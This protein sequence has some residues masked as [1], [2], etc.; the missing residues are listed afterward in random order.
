MNSKTILFSAAAAGFLFCGC[1]NQGQLPVAQMVPMPVNNGGNREV[2]IVP[3]AIP[4]TPR[5]VNNGTTGGYAPSNVQAQLKIDVK[6]STKEVKVIRDNTDPFVI[7]KPYT[8]KNADPYAVRSYLEAAVGARSISANPAQVMAVKMADGTGIV[9]VSAEEY[10]FK[11][12]KAGKGI[13]SIIKS[14]DRKGLSYAPEAG[15][16]V[17]FPRISRAA[18]LRDM[19]LKVGSHELDPQFAVAPSC[20]VVDGE[21][22]ALLVKAP[23]WSWREMQKLL[24]K[25]DRAIPEVKISYRVLEIY[26]ENDDRIGVDFQSWKNNE[27][28]DFFS[29]GMTSRRNWGTFFTSG[30]HENGWNRTSYWNFNPKWNTRYLDFMTSIGKAKCLARGVLVAQNRRSTQLQVGSGF[31][32]DRTYYTAGA[33]TIAE[34]TTEFAYLD[35][36]PDAIQ[37]EGVNKIMPYQ[38]LVRFYG[39]VSRD[40]P[41]SLPEAL[42]SAMPEKFL[43][44]ITYTQRVMGIQK[45]TSIYGDVLSQVTDAQKT[46]LT[47]QVAQAAAARAAAQIAAG[48]AA[49][50]AAA[51]GDYN[52]TFQAV[53]DAALPQ[54]LATA[55]PQVTAGMA[56][57]GTSALSQYFGGFINSSGNW[58]IPG[59]YNDYTDRDHANTHPGI[60]HG[61]LQYPMVTDGF[62]FDLKVRPEVTGKAAKLRFELDSVSLL[63]WNSDGSARTSKSGTATTVQVGLEPQEFVIGGLRKSESVRGTAGLPF[64]K[65]LPLIGRLVST[66]TESI[67]QSQLV[68]IAKVELSNPDDK[69]G[70]DVQEEVGKIIKQVNKGIK[71][72]IGNMLFQQYLL[73]DDRADREKRLDRL[74]ETITDK[75]REHR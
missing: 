35:L 59:Y 70:A 41:N 39:S 52:A 58:V 2:S 1:Q 38:D 57:L 61:W 22:N 68:L 29:A 27:G 50:A 9:L 46:L 23:A 30:V 32:Y 26:A 74:S 67:K 71:S 53:Y 66:E 19:L 65:D 20:I 72:P 4:G 43:P 21:L 17:Y 73:D 28:V 33:T 69:M 5:Y 18:N 11:D 75:Y 54:C 16:Y 40:N 34:G 31:F 13:D 25:Y 47:P 24:Q 60:I 8:L 63:G 36:N 56:T 42:I 10:R 12:S 44:H 45:G 14:L 55:T 15:V 64:L 48:K 62:K 3:Q 37:R 7:T 51:G 49:Q 6:D